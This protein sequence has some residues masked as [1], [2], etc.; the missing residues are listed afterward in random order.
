[1]VCADKVPN[2][3]SREVVLRDFQA[4]RHINDNNF[5]AVFTHFYSEHDSKHAAVR[6]TRITDLIECSFY[7]YHCEL[8]EVNDCYFVG[9]RSVS[10]VIS[11]SQNILWIYRWTGIHAVITTFSYCV[12]SYIRNRTFALP[13]ICPRTMSPGQ[14]LPGQKPPL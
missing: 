1:M 2:H 10:V 9:Q 4:T 3:K 13:Y 7:G 6:P 14:S 8:P 12:A 5:T 11:S